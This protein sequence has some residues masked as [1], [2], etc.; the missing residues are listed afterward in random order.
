MKMDFTCKARYVANGAMTDTPVR[1]CHS[2]VV[3]RDSV[4]IS[5]LVAALNDLDILAY[6]ISN[7]YLNSPLQERI[8]F[9]AGLEC[10]KSLE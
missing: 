9:V 3:S 1:L 5:F 7:A 4:R 2:S 6:D 10:G 8:W